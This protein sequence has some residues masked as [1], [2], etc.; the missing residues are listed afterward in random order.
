M[1]RTKRLTE[2]SFDGTAYIKLCGT[3]CL[4]DGEYCASDECP[5]LNEIAEKLARYE[6]LEEQ[7]AELV[8]G[9]LEKGIP[10]TQKT[11]EKVA[12]GVVDLVFKEAERGE[13][14]EQST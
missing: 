1:G 2:D 10:M 5:V 13:K 3:S 14:D 6:R 7:A 9:F 8:T 4:Y 11:L 12:G